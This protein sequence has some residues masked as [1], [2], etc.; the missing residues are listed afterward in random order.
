[1]TDATLKRIWN[2]RESI[3]RRCG[4]DAR[5]LVRFYQS[6]R[7]GNALE[8]GLDA[9]RPGNRRRRQNAPHRGRKV[10]HK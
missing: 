8:E 2:S 9:A 1:M 6:Q 10:A 5:N 3:S 4:Y 7:T